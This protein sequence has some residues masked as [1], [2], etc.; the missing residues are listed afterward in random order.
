MMYAAVRLGRMQQLVCCA[1]VTCRLLLLRNAPEDD[2]CFV[3]PVFEKV[4]KMP[5][6]L[7]MAWLTWL[8]YE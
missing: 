7:K 8:G 4:E 1:D 6:G 5:H 3:L 2:F